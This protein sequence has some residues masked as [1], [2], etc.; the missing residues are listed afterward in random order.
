MSGLLFYILDVLPVTFECGPLS[1]IIEVY[2]AIIQLKG[3]AIFFTKDTFP[4]CT[5]HCHPRE[6]F[7]VS[8]P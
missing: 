2:N 6:Y 4:D 3:N 5:Y 1:F 8:D 7:L